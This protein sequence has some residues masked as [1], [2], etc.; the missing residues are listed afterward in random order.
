[1][2]STISSGQRATRVI[3]H[4]GQRG[5][6]S[7]DR[8]GES[9]DVKRDAERLR[10]KQRQADGSADLQAQRAGDHEIRTTATD[11]HVRCHRRN[12]E[13]GERSDDHGERDDQNGAYQSDA[14]EH[15][16]EAEEHDDAQDRQEAG[17]EYTLEG[18]ESVS[19]AL[20]RSRRGCI[21]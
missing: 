5:E 3:T 6:V 14:P 12:R 16:G 17:Q 19:D 8:L 18:A 21:A 20:R 13:T 1:M 15:P 4:W 2:P 7:D 11:P 10:E 9:R